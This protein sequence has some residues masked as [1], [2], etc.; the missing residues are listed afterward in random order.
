[1][2]TAGTLTNDEMPQ[3]EKGIDRYDRIFFFEYTKMFNEAI[4]LL[5]SKR[6]NKTGKKNKDVQ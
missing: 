2:L 3:V 1:M 5:Y 4:H 6:K